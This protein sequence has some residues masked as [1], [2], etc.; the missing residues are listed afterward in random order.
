MSKRDSIRG[1]WALYRSPSVRRLAARA[2]S[3]TSL[4]F[5]AYCRDSCVGGVRLG[6]CFNNNNLF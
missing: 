1:K 2:A 4:D 5:D 6:A 3:D